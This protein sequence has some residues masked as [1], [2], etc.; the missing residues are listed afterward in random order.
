M[1]KKPKYHNIDCGFFP[2]TIKLCFSDK[3]FQKILKDYDVP[4][5]ATA[6]DIGVAETHML[7]DGR[8]SIIILA[9]DLVECA[10]DL[11][12][13]A[14]TI[15]HEATHCA[16]RIFDHI[17]EE[18]NQIGEETRAYLTEHIVRQITQAAYEELFKNARKTG[19]SVFDTNGE[20]K[21]GDE[22]EV[23]VDNNGSAGPDRVAEQKT[24]FRR[25]KNG[26]GRGIGKAK[27]S[28]QSVGR[29]KFS[30]VD[31]KEQK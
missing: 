22:P 15:A 23:S 20:V 25:T 9:F 5:R 12:Y 3:D 31:F 30:S 21:K 19:R 29:T 7:S 11:A 28:F 26:K 4:V 1:I 18:I 8:Q 2:S 14:G 27:N 17:G 24:L 10:T 16:Q 6:L 13:L